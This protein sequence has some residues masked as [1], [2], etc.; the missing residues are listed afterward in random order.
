M[1][2]DSHQ[3]VYFEMTNTSQ[4]DRACAILQRWPSE[5]GNREALVQEHDQVWILDVD[6]V[7]IVID[8]FSFPMTDPADLAEMRAIVQGLQIQPRSAP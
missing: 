6:G 1:T 2:I 4:E 5:F 3:G 7:R 8:A